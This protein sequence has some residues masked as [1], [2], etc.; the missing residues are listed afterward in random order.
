MMQRVA[1]FG[2]V[3]I[4]G[5]MCLPPEA[6]RGGVRPLGRGTA[7]VVARHLYG[8]PQVEHGTLVKTQLVTSDG[9]KVTINYAGH[10]NDTFV[11][12]AGT[13]SEFATR[14]SDFTATLRSGGIEALILPLSKK[15]DALIG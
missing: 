13:I 14:R 2:F 9:D 4:V 5:L 15:A 11:Y 6:G 12:L 3:L 10:D 7:F 1:R 8:E